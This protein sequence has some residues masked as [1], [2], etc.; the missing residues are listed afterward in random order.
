MAPGLRGQEQGKSVFGHSL[1]ELF[2]FPWNFPQLFSFSLELS[3][4]SVKGRGMG[5][6]AHICTMAVAFNN[7]G[8]ISH[9]LVPSV[10]RCWQY[11]RLLMTFH[12][13]FFSAGWSVLIMLAKG[14][15]ENSATR[16]SEQKTFNIKSNLSLLNHFW[17]T[18]R[19]DDL[20]DLYFLREILP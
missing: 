14:G 12:H 4:I 1:S 15:I 6:R 10:I 16:K 9:K 13:C 3:K 19:N 20:F 18:A 5:G 11:P 8:V 7:A 2:S 17:L